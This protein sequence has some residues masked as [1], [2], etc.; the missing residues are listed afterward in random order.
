MN[1]QSGF[2]PLIEKSYDGIV[3]LNREG[4]IRYVNPAAEILFGRNKQDMLGEQFGFPI[5]NGENSEITIL[6][7]QN[8]LKTV[9]MRM[10]EIVWNEESVNLCSLHDI[11]QRKQTESELIQAKEKAEENDRLKTYFLQNISHEIRTPMNGIIGFIELI[12]AEDTSEE[13]KMH[14][15]DIV[16][17]SSLRLFNL[18]I[19]LVDISRIETGQIKIIEEEFSVSKLVYD[20]FAFFKHNNDLNKKGLQF[21]QGKSLPDN[22]SNITSDREKIYQ[23]YSH[24][25]KNA[26][27]FTEN[28]YIEVGYSKQPDSYHFYV[29]D[30]GIGIK[31][32]LADLIFQRFRQG[33]DGYSRGY[34][35][36]G[37]GLAISKSY[38]EKLGGTIWV[39]SSP[40]NGSTLYFSLP[41]SKLTVKRPEVEKIQD[42][43]IDTNLHNNFLWEGYK[44]VIVEDDESN[45]FF[46]KTMLEPTR[47]ELIC[48]SNG[49]EFRELYNNLSTFSLVLL[50]IRLPDV[51]GWDLATEIKSLYPALPII[52][53][54]AYAMLADQ[55]KSDELGC[56]GFITKPI[57]RSL[58]L[59]M[60]SDYLPGTIH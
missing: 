8:S 33:Q 26:I 60:I 37:L 56:E 7:L 28:G 32:E 16:Q 27:K 21:L 45:M 53:Q 11:T 34:D 36:L 25:I 9:E 50:D 51:N 57:N 58:L 1:K 29:K 38:V 12:K 42:P 13:S 44:I 10:V 4:I 6:G 2:Q 14:F 35:G 23:I 59:K 31:P 52:V 3:V 41:I 5:V 19:D 48:A 22:E 49:A 40:G 47:A 39:E 17:Q 30:S 54:T 46:L 24:L 43:E 55:R 15:L 20:L 18:I